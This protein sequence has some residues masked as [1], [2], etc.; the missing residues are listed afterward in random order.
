MDSQSTIRSRRTNAA[1]LPFNTCLVVYSLF[2][3]D[4][5][6]TIEFNMNIKEVKRLLFESACKGDTAM[7]HAALSAGANVNAV[8]E[9]GSSSLMVASYIGHVEC[10]NALLAAGA[11]INAVDDEGFSSL[12]LAA[13][14]GHVECV[15]ALLAAGA[16]VNPE[17]R[18][19]NI[20]KTETFPTLPEAI[21]D[22]KA[23]PPTARIRQRIFFFVIFSPKKMHDITV[24]K[25]GDV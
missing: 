13:Y 3:I 19:I 5:K 17:A 23:H 18:P 11:D 4:Y 21:P 8:N 24:T 10:V 7:L 9:N 12:A 14:N 16:Y 25:I 1:F 2:L 22:T 20:P 15:N 6:E